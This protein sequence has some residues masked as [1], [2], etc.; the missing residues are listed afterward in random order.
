LETEI[1]PSRRTYVN[2]YFRYTGLPKKKTS[3]KL[4]Y[5]SLDFNYLYTKLNNNIYRVLGMVSQEFQG[6]FVGENVVE[7]LNTIFPNM[8]GF[9]KNK[10]FKWCPTVWELLHHFIVMIIK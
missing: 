9:L 8:N 10:N 3:P 2:I 1:C 5:L 7:N 4:P 6:E